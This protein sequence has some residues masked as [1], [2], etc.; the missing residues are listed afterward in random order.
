MKLQPNY[1][2]SYFRF[3]EYPADESTSLDL[4]QVAVVTM[5]HLDRL[6]MKHQH[7]PNEDEPPTNESSTTRL[8]FILDI[9]EET[10]LFL[11]NLLAS[12]WT[13][14]LDGRV[15]FP[16]PKQDQ[17]CIAVSALNILRHGSLDVVGKRVHN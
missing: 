7:Q 1:E 13:P 16:P 6:A 14:H 15:R 17:E 10:F 2:F 3:L 8:P 9:S 5:C 4:R 12:V 11:D